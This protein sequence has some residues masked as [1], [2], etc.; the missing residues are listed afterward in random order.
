MSK[1]PRTETRGEGYALLYFHLWVREAL[2]WEEDGV[3]WT[4][5]AG[6]IH[7]RNRSFVKS[8]FCHYLAVQS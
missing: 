2:S 3:D 7:T 6:Q 4:G 1:G 8:W 5:E